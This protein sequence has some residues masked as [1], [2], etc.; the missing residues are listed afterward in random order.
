MCSWLPGL[1]DVPRALICAKQTP[2]PKGVRTQVPP[3]SV[4]L[5]L[6]PVCAAPAPRSERGARGPGAERRPGAHGGGVSRVQNAN[7]DRGHVEFARPAG[8]KTRRRV[9]A[10]A[11]GL[12]LPLRR[13]LFFGDTSPAYLTYRSAW[14]FFPFRTPSSVGFSL[15]L[16][17]SVQ[18]Y[19]AETIRN[20]TNTKQYRACEPNS[21]P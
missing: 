17:L 6:T 7:A 9:P 1:Q 11:A 3:H 21:V 5:V 20:K 4:C 14:Y 12:W 13:A 2:P 8:R 15:S 18:S 10:R 16:K 19:T